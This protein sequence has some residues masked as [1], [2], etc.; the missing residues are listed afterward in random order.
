MCEG[1]IMWFN[2]LKGV[3][4][5]RVDD[6]FIKALEAIFDEVVSEF[7]AR[8]G[9][10]I[11]ITQTYEIGSYANELIIGIEQK[12]NIIPNYLKVEFNIPSLEISPI[13]FE[14]DTHTE[15][16]DKLKILD[17]KLS[18]SEQD[19]GHTWAS[20]RKWYRDTIKEVMK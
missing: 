3:Y 12:R 9:P 15:L 8:L 7:D 1:V 18:N 11:T 16:V 10:K 14:Y 2:I 6:F 5:D 20:F 19:I 4:D 17:K 13:T